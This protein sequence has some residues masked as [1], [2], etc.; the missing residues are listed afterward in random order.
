MGSKLGIHHEIFDQVIWFNPV[1][2]AAG[3]LTDLKV[4]GSDPYGSVGVI[5]LA[6]LKLKFKLRIAGFDADFHHF[7][8]RHSL[9]ETGDALAGRIARESRPVSLVCHSMGGLVARAAIARGAPVE[10]VLQLGTPNRGSFAPVQVIRATYDTVVQLARLDLFHTAKDL[11]EG[12][13]RTFPGLYE[14]LPFANAGT[15]IDLFR[16]SPGR[17][18]SRAPSP[19]AWRP[20]KPSRKPCLRAMAGSSSSRE[21]IRAPSPVSSGATPSSC[22][23]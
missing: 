16:W 8:W 11:S 20:L 18:T 2:I 14:M 5:L 12:V 7:D 13:L 15:A 17:T 4:N 1:Q 23:P 21:S 10:K 9:A 6:Y 19:S 3:K 22:T